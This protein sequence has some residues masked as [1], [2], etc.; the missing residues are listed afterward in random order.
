MRP[1]DLSVRLSPKRVLCGGFAE[2]DV[3][4]TAIPSPP[5]PSPSPSNSVPEILSR[6]AN[7]LPS[8][9]GPVSP[10]LVAFVAWLLLPQNVFGGLRWSIARLRGRRPK[11]DKRRAAQRAR[12]ASAMAAQVARVSE[13]EEW[14][15][16]RFAELDAEVEV[17]GRQARG[18]LRRRRR[19]TIRRVPSLSIALEESSDSV[20]LLEGEPG[21]G[22][23]VALRH[24]A[25]RL[26]TEVKEHLLEPQGVPPNRDGGLCGRIDLRQSF[27]Q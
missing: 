13:L 26:A 18:L 19:E 16:E 20:I 14:R 15:D 7:H 24:V 9:L 21:S 3:P 23:S 25:S 27:D 4:M 10:F 12:F 8:W 22:K 17:H 5:S 1:G 6:V 11:R 2:D